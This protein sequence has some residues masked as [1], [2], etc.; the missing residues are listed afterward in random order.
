MNPEI[1]RRFFE[2]MVE[3]R[4]TEGKE[5]IMGYGAIFN[6]KSAL[7]WGMFEEKI[8]PGAFDKADLS[9]IR[10]LINH[11]ANLILGRT[12]SG[13]C[14]VFIDERG[15]RYEITPPET[16]Y[17]KDLIVSMKRGDI[18]QSSFAFT[19]DEDGDEWDDTVEPWQR[20]ITKIKR[21]Y[22]VS[23]V[24]FAAYPDAS[25]G[26]GKRD[27]TQKERELYGLSIR[28]TEKLLEIAERR[29]LAEVEMTRLETYLRT[30]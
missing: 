2:S 9:D 10:G 7:I 27:L 17:C 26:I 29:K 24:T 5:L 11:Q 13:T 19:I 20:T 8:A 18:N 6:I 15:L 16:S 3:C 22:D 12:K 23:P 14:R 1:E 4:Q 30:L 25:A 28:T 21:V